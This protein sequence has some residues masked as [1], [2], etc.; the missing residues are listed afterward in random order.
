MDERKKSAQ[1]TDSYNYTIEFLFCS[2]DFLAWLT[3]L[4]YFK[5]TLYRVWHLSYFK[6][7]AI[8]LASHLPTAKSLLKHLNRRT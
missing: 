7:I 4:Q 6:K 3:W 2:A 1:K 5:S 8:P